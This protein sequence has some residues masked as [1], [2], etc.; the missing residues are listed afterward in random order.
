MPFQVGDLRAPSI[1]PQWGGIYEE[2]AAHAFFG[3]FHT[4]NR[5]FKQNFLLGERVVFII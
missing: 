5:A 2:P 3:F 1:A 4:L